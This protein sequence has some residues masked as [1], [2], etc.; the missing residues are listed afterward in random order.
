MREE[1]VPCDESMY[2]LFGQFFNPT[3]EGLVYV[4]APKLHYQS[5]VVHFLVSCIGNHIRIDLKCIIIRIFCGLFNLFNLFNLF[6]HLFNLWLV[7]NRFYR[8]LSILEGDFRVFN[9]KMS[10]KHKEVIPA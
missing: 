5:T 6:D 7:Y 4:K 8:L 2:R 10:S 3:N 1:Y 9:L